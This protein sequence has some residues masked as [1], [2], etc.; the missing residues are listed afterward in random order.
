MD[1]EIRF[2]VVLC[3]LLLVASSFLST[4]FPDT[5]IYVLDGL[6]CYPISKMSVLTLF[7]VVVTTSL[8]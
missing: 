8:G 1:H 7:S 2:C 4:L 3:I 6:N 5:F